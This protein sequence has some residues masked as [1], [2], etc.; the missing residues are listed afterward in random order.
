MTTLECHRHRHQH[1]S[2][3]K[4]DYNPDEGQTTLGDGARQGRP[5][6]GRTTTAEARIRVIFFQLTGLGG[7]TEQIGIAFSRIILSLIR[8]TT[9]LV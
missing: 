6:Q 8:N 9:I 5:R 1:G 4:T 2:T 3:Q 7:V